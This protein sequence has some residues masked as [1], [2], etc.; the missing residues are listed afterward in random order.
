MKKITITLLCVLCLGA[1]KQ[2]PV[3]RMK[4]AVKVSLPTPMMLPMPD[5]AVIPP[6]TNV[7]TFTLCT[8]GFTP[9]ASAGVT[10]YRVYVGTN[11]GIYYRNFD[12]GL[13][14]QFV[15]SNLFYEVPCFVAMKS[16]GNGIPGDQF[17]SELPWPPAREEYVRITDGS[18]IAVTFTNLPANQFWRVAVTATNKTLQAAGELRAFGTI[19]FNLGS[20]T[21]PVTNQTPPMLLISKDNN[22]DAHERPEQ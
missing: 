8:V 9:S 17:S 21:I 7:Y 19:W 3:V 22:I 6:D 12:I 4:R 14:N 16:L 13:T 15:V 20:T 1:A 18:G 2:D 11:S 5:F 10:G